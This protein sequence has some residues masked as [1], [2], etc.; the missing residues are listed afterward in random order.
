MVSLVEQIAGKIYSKHNKNDELGDLSINEIIVLV[1]SEIG[2]IRDYTGHQKKQLA[3]Q[4]IKYLLN[5]SYINA[6]NP[7]LLDKSLSSLIDTVYKIHRGKLYKKVKTKKGLKEA[8]ETQ[9]ERLS[10]LS[11]A[12]ILEVVTFALKVSGI[13]H[14]EVMID[15]LVDFLSKFNVAPGLITRNS[16]GSLID[17]VSRIIN[18][19]FEISGEHISLIKRILRAL[20]CI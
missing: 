3:I 16:I 18:K 4:V 7:E 15:I 2:K 8:L 13:D 1:M 11:Y 14:K 20:K 9:F 12:D 19:E 17:L 5:N 6:N 10:D